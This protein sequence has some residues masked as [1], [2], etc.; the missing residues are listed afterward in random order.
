[1]GV[2]V[3]WVCGGLCMGVEGVYAGVCAG[4]CRCG[5]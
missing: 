4:V 3:W 1:M 2:C 5:W